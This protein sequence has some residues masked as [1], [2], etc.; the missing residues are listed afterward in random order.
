MER[1]MSEHEELT[2]PLHHSCAA[3]KGRAGRFWSRP[4]P[5]A[6]ARPAQEM[7]AGRALMGRRAFK[8]ALKAFGESLQLKRGLIMRW[9]LVC[10]WAGWDV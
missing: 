6:T 8:R 5:P 10:E 1:D 7:T 4:R 9:L 3:H 2:Q